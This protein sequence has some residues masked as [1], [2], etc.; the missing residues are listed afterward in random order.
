GLAEPTD[1]QDQQFAFAWWQGR[2]CTHHMVT[3][4]AE[5]LRGF[6]MTGNRTKDVVHA[7]FLVDRF[8]NLTLLFRPFSFGQWC[9][10]RLGQFHRNTSCG[11]IYS[12]S[13]LYHFFTVPRKRLPIEKEYR[14][15]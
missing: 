8:E 10:P 9:N 1:A 14:V 12:V 11:R 5:L 15:S 6:P 4:D 7:P 13:L 3:P 2:C